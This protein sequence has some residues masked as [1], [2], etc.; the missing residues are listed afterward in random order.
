MDVRSKEILVMEFI[1]TMDL[2]Q[3]FQPEEVVEAFYTFAR[4]K[5]QDAMK[6]VVQTHRL[7]EEGL[8]YIHKAIQRGYASM[9]GTELDAIL[10]PTSRMAGAREAKK[11]E[12]QHAIQQ[13]AETFVGI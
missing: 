11:Q 12:V 9:E 8:M 3:Q 4:Q 1:Q 6:E 13:I 10:P 5:K 2:T 7:K